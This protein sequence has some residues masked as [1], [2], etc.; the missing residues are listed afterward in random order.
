MLRLRDVARQWSVRAARRRLFALWLANFAQM[1]AGAYLLPFVIRRAV[2]LVPG[3]ADAAWQTI[4]GYLIVPFIV[5]APISA[6]LVGRLPKHRL[7][8]FAALCNLIMAGAVGYFAARHA[9]SDVAF[10]LM[11]CL[12]A[13]TAVFVTARDALLPEAA[14]EAE[15]PL[16][17]VVGWMSAGGAAALVLGMFALPY[18]HYRYLWPVL[19]QLA[20]EMVDRL[21]KNELPTMIVE[22]CVLQLLSGA[23]SLLARFPS[24]V[25]LPSQPPQLGFFASARRILAEPQ[26]RKALLAQAFVDGLLLIGVAATFGNL[27]GWKFPEQF[28]FGLHPFYWLAW[29]AVA[30]CL[31]ASLQGH[32]RR[33]LGFIP[34]AATAI[35]IIFQWA[36]SI[37]YEPWLPLALGALCGLLRVPAA[38]SY[39]LLLPED[40]RSGGVA[41][42][43]AASCLTGVIFAALFSGLSF[44][45]HLSPL[46]L[47]WICIGLLFA[48]MVLAWVCYFREALELVIEVL[49]WAIYRIRSRGPGKYEIPP[50]GPLLVVANH[51]SWLDPI[52]LAK[53]IPR[54]IIPMM[55]SRFYDMPVLRWFM[56]HVVHAIRVQASQFRREAPEL[57]EAVAAL[58]QG[59]CV[60]I[61]P[62]GF[63]RRSEE[64]PLRQFGQG[65]WRILSKRPTTPV[66]VC[67]IEGGW[68]SYTSYAGGAPTV[69]KRFDFWR[70]I[71]I[72]IETPEVLDPALLEDARATRLH[73]MRVCLEARRHLGLEPLAKVEVLGEEQEV[74]E[75]AQEPP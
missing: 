21:T 38:A 2:W 16:S 67:W 23:T 9:P 28:M 45:G 17:R 31:L 25:T 11:A 15:L 74:Y 61:F 35:A 41:L 70:R 56:V 48:G 33:M 42:G 24:P 53:V 6:V 1:L 75:Q 22:V 71:R 54:R 58:D 3:H 4:L 34:L 73:L 19:L 62:E 66:V 72:A 7:L 69:N 10:Y 40:A 36:V 18:L 13:G 60:T 26:S 39:L 37:W 44:F 64:R 59:E 30:G 52:W 57:D 29:G 12:I 14:H 43:R 68:G 20:P 49:I 63:M 51:S 50:R 27:L 47:V 65:V 46:P 5:L 8:F 55:T 32:P